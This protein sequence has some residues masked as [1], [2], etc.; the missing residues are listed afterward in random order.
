MVGDLALHNTL[1]RG[2]PPSTGPGLIIDPIPRIGPWAFDAAYCQ[3]N[4]G[5][6]DVQ[7][8]ARLAGCR[9][10]LGLPVGAAG[11]LPRIAALLLAWTG[12]SWWV[13][14]PNWRTIPAW[15]TH[16]AD[17]LTEAAALA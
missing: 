5:A 4:A 16:I 17:Y 1:C 9:E 13:G 10:R 12:A 6:P 3:T 15:A 11:D 2:A 8:V 7:L 14:M